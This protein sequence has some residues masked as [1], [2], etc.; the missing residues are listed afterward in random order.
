MSIQGTLALVG[1]V[2]L[3]LGVAASARRATL[4]SSARE[5]E[6]GQGSIPVTPV[7]SP[8]AGGSGSNAIGIALVI[9]G[10]VALLAAGVLVV[11]MWVLLSGLF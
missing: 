8:R 2:L 11:A 6:V 5:P 3:A 10:V 1:I 4:S 9:A 7:G